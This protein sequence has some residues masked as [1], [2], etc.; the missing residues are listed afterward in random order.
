MATTRRLTTILA[1]D[2]AAYARLVGA[3]EEGTLE[4]LSAHR[5]Q[6]VDPKIGEHGGRIVNT[7]GDGLIAEFPSVVEA[8]RCAIEVQRG[9]LD[10]EAKLTDEQ[11][12]RYRIG[13]NL[14]DVVVEGSD[15]L[16]DGVNIAARLEALA[17]PGGICV[18][19][20]VRDQ[21]RDR[22]PYPLDDLGDQSFK[23]ISRPVRT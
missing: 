21:I 2:V 20:T 13:I 5:R 6:W 10:R 18:S 23:N 16:G 3:D 22:L 12:I 4:R 11:Q 9:M 1:A 8:M 17:E 15:L 7:A 19:R 14:G